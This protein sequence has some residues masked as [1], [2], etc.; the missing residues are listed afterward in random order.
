LITGDRSDLSTDL[1]AAFSRSG[2]SHILSI[3][4][5]H[6][7]LIIFNTYLLLMRLFGRKKLCNLITILLAVA[8][9]VFTGASPSIIRAAFMCSAIFAAELIDERSD[10]VI[11]LS[12]VLVLLLLF[13]PYSVINLSLQLSFLAS[14]GIL[15]TLHNFDSFYEKHRNLRAV[16]L[17][18]DPAVMSVAATLFSTPVLLARFDYISIVSPIAN[19]LVN[20]FISL[21]MLL[22][23]VLVPVALL[24]KW[25]AVIPAMIYKAIEAI[26]SF[27]ADMR[28]ACVSVYLPYIK[29]LFIPSFVIVIAFGAFRFK[30]S[31]TVFFACFISTLL[32]YGGCFI[33]QNQ[34]Y[35]DNACLFVDDGVTSSFTFYADENMTVLVDGGGSMGV[36]EEVLECGH[37]YIDVYVVTACNE[38]SVKRLE[39]TVPYT[40]IHT[41]FVPQEENDYTKATLELA[42]KYGCRVS[43]YKNNKLKLG[44]FE[45]QT[46]DNE[47]G[48]NSY[49]INATKKEKTVT[50][51]G[52]TKFLYDTPPIKGDA[53]V[54]TRPSMEGNILQRVIDCSY[55]KVYIY[56]IDTDIYTRLLIQ[57][58][59]TKQTFKYSGNALFRFG[60]CGVV[61]E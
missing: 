17:I 37:T 48:T 47:G 8:Y 28:Y 55:E 2:L 54:L 57:N 43:R 45:V 9:A 58:E 14:L 16:R 44:G 32:I 5:Q 27:F 23:I 20:I 41:V 26:S 15:F 25:V 3:S 10:P 61:K 50:V 6:F 13:N 7:S 1:E 56:D 46:A 19:V 36:S 30:R 60:K 31:M 12:A 21:A 11:N 59:V 35:K 18:I 4:G 51:L 22:G 38:N 33:L 39:R 29:L 42:V 49:L 53:L 40:P 34:G 52:P 24:F